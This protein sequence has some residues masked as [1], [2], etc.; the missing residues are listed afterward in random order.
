MLFATEAFESFNAVIHA[1]KVF[2]AIDKHPLVT[3][4]WHS[5]RETIFA[6]FLA[7][8]IFFQANFMSFGGRILRTSLPWIGLQSGQVQHI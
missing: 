8:A 5:H 6:I 3:L 2:T 1:K 7:V 4:P